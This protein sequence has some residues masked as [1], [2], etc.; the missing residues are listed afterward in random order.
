MNPTWE[1]T[2]WR[3]G[4]MTAQK[5]LERLGQPRNAQWDDILKRLAPAPAKDGVYL[6]YEG[7]DTYSRQWAY[8]HP[9]MLGALGVLPGE[10]IDR[11]MMAATARK[12][13]ESW[14]FS[15]VW[16]WDFGMAAMAAV[17]TGQ[18]E[19][20]VDFLLMDAATNHYMANGCCYQRENVPAY[21][22]ANGGLLSAIAMMAGGW[23]GGRGWGKRLRFPRA[24]GGM[25]E[26][27]DLGGGC[28]G[29]FMDE[30]E[31]G[32]E[33]RQICVLREREVGVLPVFERKMGVGGGEAG[34][35]FLVSWYVGEERGVK[36]RSLAHR[37]DNFAS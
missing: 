2:A 11:K 17:R 32:G 13:R 28:K 6:Q 18:A 29:T 15:R 23:N 27:R 19:L 8:E 20:A 35:E 3:F 7:Q 1:L 25:C 31:P 37:D 12:V 14:D 21:F 22:P 26:R 33:D 34:D 36:L 30:K 5:W 9:S 16:G 10:G 24:G 4:L